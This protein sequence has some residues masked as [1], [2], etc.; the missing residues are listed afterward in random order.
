MLKDG[1]DLAFRDFAEPQKSCVPQEFTFSAATVAR[2]A[3]VVFFVGSIAADRPSILRWWID[4]VEQ[5]QVCDPFSNP[6]DGPEWAETV[7]DITIPAGATSVTFQPVSDVCPTSPYYPNGNPQSF[8]W[9]AGAVAIE[10]IPM[11]EGCTGGW[12]M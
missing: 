4:G 5:P 11:G 10:G 1:N 6:N 9:V 7:I 12:V 3:K 2:Q 8:A